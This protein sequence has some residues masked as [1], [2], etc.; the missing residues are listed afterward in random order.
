MPKTR[1]GGWEISY[2]ETGGGYPLIYIHGGFGGLASALGPSGSPLREAVRV[3]F[4]GFGL[5]EYDRRN[6][7]QSEMRSAP[8]DQDDIADETADLLGQLGVEEAV[9]VGDSMGGTIAQSLALARPEMVS[10][11][12]L[13]EASAHM[14]DAPFYRPMTEMVELASR[15]GSD[16]VFERRREAIYSPQLSPLRRP[17]VTDGDRREMQER[18]DTQVRAV[19]EAPEEQVKAIA[20]GE[21]CNWR[22]HAGFDTRDRLGEL[23]EHRVFVLHGDADSV[24]PTEHGVELANGISGAE[25]VLIPGGDHGILMWPKAREALR[26]WVEAEVG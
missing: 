15:E 17:G 16:A 18:L 13:V 23:A 8:Y 3:T 19:R 9:I 1:I 7:G 6:C 12:A 24:V 21:L 10:A 11:L 20:L 14:K 26:S 25:L 4:E 5:I 2:T 22:A